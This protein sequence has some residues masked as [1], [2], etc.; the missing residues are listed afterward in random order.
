VT[1][2]VELFLGQLP[3]SYIFLFAFQLEAKLGLALATGES[4][5]V[6]GQ[7]ILNSAA[8]EALVEVSDQ[9]RSLAASWLASAKVK[10]KAW[11]AAT[12]SSSS[13]PESGSGGVQ[14]I[15]TNMLGVEIKTSMKISILLHDQH[16]C[17]SV[18]G[19]NWRPDVVGVARNG[20]LLPTSTGVIIELKGQQENYAAPANIHQVQQV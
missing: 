4:D 10:G 7:R 16:L 11:K 18:C 14:E 5:S 9:S 8:R 6:V 20:A 19:R 12:K 17:S 3:F 1:R 13:L 2:K 15:V